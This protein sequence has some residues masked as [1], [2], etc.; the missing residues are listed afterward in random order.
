MAAGGRLLPLSS[1]MDRRHRS[2][3][4]LGSNIMMLAKPVSIVTGAGI[5]VAH[6][7]V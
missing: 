3:F 1:A 2:L 6:I 7:E 5:K 4:S